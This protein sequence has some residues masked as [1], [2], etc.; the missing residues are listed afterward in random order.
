MFKTIVSTDIAQEI[1][2]RYRRKFLRPDFEQ[3]NAAF[4]CKNLPWCYYKDSKVYDTGELYKV[5]I[6]PDTIVY[7]HDERKEI[8]YH[9]TFREVYN[10]VIKL[11]P[12][13]EVDLEVFDDE[14]E[15]TVAITHEDCIILC[16]LDIIVSDSSQR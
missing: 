7:C 8:M 2:E 14:M 5:P 10:F 12:W 4:N 15:W 6:A 3:F 9:T 13:D 16:G 11:E 1:M